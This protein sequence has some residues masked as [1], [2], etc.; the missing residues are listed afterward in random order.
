MPDLTWRDGDFVDCYEAW[1]AGL[2]V[3]IQKMDETGFW[4]LDSSFEDQEEFRADTLD[5][6]KRIAVEAIQRQLRAA[7]EAWGVPLG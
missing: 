3:E 5:D 7:C 4:W 2:R 1:L 6:A